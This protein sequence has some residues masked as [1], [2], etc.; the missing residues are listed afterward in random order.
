V[1]SVPPAPPHSRRARRTRMPAAASSSV[2]GTDRQP[3]GLS[4]HA[5]DG[6]ASKRP[7]SWTTLG[8]ARPPPCSNGTWRS[9]VA[10]SLW[11]REVAGSSPA[12]P[13]TPSDAAHDEIIHWVPGI[14]WTCPDQR[15][16]AFTS[17]RVLAS[18]CSQQIG[19]RALEVHRRGRS[20][21]AEL[22]P[23]KLVMR[24]R[25]PSPAQQS[26]LRFRR[27]AA[28]FSVVTRLS[29]AY[30]VCRRFPSSCVPTVSQRV[31]KAEAVGIG[32]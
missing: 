31:R 22:Q 28:H 1:C 15:R 32:E 2:A 29:L 20:S 6:A 17:T 18:P 11:G 19:S 5:S 10:R 25:F 30:V 3:V 26:E 4:I 7:G 12:V 8:C 24:V 27:S 23:S 14:C 16:H 21:M 13:T 9:L